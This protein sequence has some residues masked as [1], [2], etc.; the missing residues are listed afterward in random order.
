MQVR[1]LNTNYNSKDTVKYFAHFIARALLIALSF[2]VVSISVIAIFVV[3]DTVYNVN[4]GNNVVPL[5]GGYIIITE[6]MVPTIKV[7]DAVLVKRSESN[8]LNI[9]DIITFKSIDERYDGLVVT[10]RIVGSQNISTGDLVYRT[11]G[12]NNKLEDMAVVPEE[13][14]FGRVILKIPKLGYVKDFLNKPIGFILCIIIPIVMIIV[15]NIKNINI[16]SREEELI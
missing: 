8:E 6:S 15:I 7:N 16:S 10:H 14:I 5:F 12:D 1:G 9:G 13:N 3:G 4:K 2:I 11:K